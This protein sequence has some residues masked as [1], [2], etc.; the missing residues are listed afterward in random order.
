[1]RNWIFL[2]VEYCSIYW[3][4]STM[5]FKLLYI[6]WNKHQNGFSSLSWSRHLCVCFWFRIHADISYIASF[7]LIKISDSYI[8]KTFRVFLPYRWFSCK[9]CS[10]CLKLAASLCQNY[11]MWKAQLSNATFREAKRYTKLLSMVELSAE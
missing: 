5:C 7:M 2:H 3:S 1:M 4:Y 11:W 9:L 6:F 8:C 10:C